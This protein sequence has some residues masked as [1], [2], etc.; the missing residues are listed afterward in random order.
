[1]LHPLIHQ[2]TTDHSHLIHLT[3]SQS[4]VNYS[5]THYIITH[6]PTTHPC[7][8]SSSLHHLT[9]QPLTHIYVFISHRLSSFSEA[10]TCCLH[11]NPSFHPHIHQP[12]TDPLTSSLLPFS[13]PP[14]NHWPT[15]TTSS[16]SPF[17][18]HH[19]TNNLLTKSST[20][21]LKFHQTGNISFIRYTFIHPF[22]LSSISQQLTQ[23]MTSSSILPSSQPSAAHSLTHYIFIHLIHQ[24]NNNSYPTS[25]SIPFNYQSTT[26]KLKHLQ[27]HIHPLINHLTT[28]THSLLHS[29]LHP[30]THQPTNHSPTTSSP[31]LSSSHP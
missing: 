19:T 31:T 18:I 7:T 23:L 4:S 24:A 22:I 16:I 2:P 6:H 15:F 25:S 12:T 17:S 3:S 5:P 11:F 21:P 8:T 10:V 20:I 29:S 28:Y 30:L 26:V 27:P 13:R 14:P 9:H 1:M